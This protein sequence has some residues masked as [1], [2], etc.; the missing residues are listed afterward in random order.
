MIFKNIINGFLTNLFS[1]KLVRVSKNTDKPFLINTFTTQ[2]LIYL[3]ELVRRVENVEGDIVECGVG[4]GYSLYSI[5]NSL[6]ML[7]STK[8]IW[9]YDS[10]EGL[11]TPAVED[12]PSRKNVKIVQGDLNF[13]EKYV[14]GRLTV[15]GL[16]QEYIDSNIKF[17]K[18]YFEDS[19]KIVI[20]EKIAFLHIDVDLYDSYMVVLNQMYTRVQQGGI[21]AFDEYSDNKWVGAKKAVD[22][23]FQD[24]PEKPVKGRGIDRYYVVKQ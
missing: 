21:I 2:K 7:N 23:F 13:S 6:Q 19:F 4:W 3:N 16:S 14:I 18:G 22:F 15:S 20:P 5:C 8:K 9:G 17:V 1:V 12:E 11:P 24:K 10:F